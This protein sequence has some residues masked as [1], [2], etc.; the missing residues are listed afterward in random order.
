MVGEQVSKPHCHVLL[1]NMECTGHFEGISRNL[2]AV[3]MPRLL[4]A[5][6]VASGITVLHQCDIIHGDLKLDNIVVMRS[7]GSYSGYHCKDL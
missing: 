3:Y 6:D 1:L 4:L 5:G 2:S 7:W